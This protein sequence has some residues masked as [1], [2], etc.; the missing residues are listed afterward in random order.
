ML[1]LGI[2]PLANNL[3]RPEDL[4]KSE[5]RFPL[6]LFVCNRCFL[7]QLGEI[8]SPVELFSEYLYLSSFSESMLQHARKAAERYTHDYL[9]GADSFVVEIASNDGY[10]LQYFKGISTLG[11]EPAEN[12]ARIA[13]QKG[14]A[15]LVRFFGRS[16]AEII[17]R[18]KRH[19]DLIL[20][21][22]VF[23]HAPEI[24]DFVF[25]LKLL[26]APRGRIVLEFPY[27]V[28][29]IE[30]GEFDTIYHEH[31]FYF[32]L[33]PLMGLFQRANLVITDVEHLDI[34]GGSLRL[35]VRH[36]REGMESENV[37]RLLAREKEK[38][39]TGLHY[40]QRLSHHVDTLRR[41]LCEL[42]LRLKSERKRL[43]AYGAAAKGS[44]LLNTLRI[45]R[46]TLDFVADRSH[47]KQ[48]RLMPGVQ[49]PIVSPEQ[50]LEQMPDYLLL[51]S[52]NF[53]DEILEQQK[54]YRSQGGKFIIPLP[55]LRVV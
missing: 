4:G 44:V 6:R 1:D 40:Y 34:H 26:L 17:V 36:V 52:W 39:L 7:V 43:A 16:T 24:E 41:D 29:L 13:R 23:A 51:L 55:Q 46:E 32:S 48:G 45:G 38:G 31:V 3:L 54:L 35:F 47:Y 22:N 30:G 19:A 50:I 49:I 9:L 5:P 33:T 28:D 8:V 25:G 2:Q 15:T 12:I 27:L 21:N 37:T 18:D 10:F 42:L 53:A 20:A 11:I 14:I